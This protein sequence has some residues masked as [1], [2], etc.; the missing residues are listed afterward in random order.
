MDILS[1][2]FVNYADI[3]WDYFVMLFSLC[4]GMQ[5]CAALDFFKNI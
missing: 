5:A 4:A 1:F 2:S 3:E